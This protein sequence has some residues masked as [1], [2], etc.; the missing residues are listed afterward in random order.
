MR[1]PFLREEQVKSCQAAPF[2][3]SLARSAASHAGERCTSLDHTS[4][5]VARQSREAHPDT[6]RCPF[7]RESLVQFCSAAPR[8]IYV[9]WSESLDLRCGHDAH[10]FCELFLATGGASARGPAHAVSDPEEGQTALV[11]GVPV[12]GWLFFADNHLWLDLGD[13]GLCHLGIDALLAQVVGRADGLTFL[14]ERGEARP[15]VVL[16]RR[17]VDLT[18]VFAR[19]L[20][21]VAANTRLR[22]SLERL[23]ADPYGAGWLFTARSHGGRGWRDPRESLSGGLRHGASAR[24]WMAAD[25]RRLSAI[26]H[27][28]LLSR[29]GAPPMPADGGRFAPDLLDVLDREDVVRLFAELFPLPV[30]SRSS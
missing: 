7:L 15:A 14:V 17:G 25:V 10:R 3:K 30:E 28:R 21:L 23:T 19:P 8:P 20:P 2:R 5:P 13:D 4:C 16:T 1:C 24:A 18:L 12:P 9:P 29:H 27:Q 11:E 22:S 6:S 26:A